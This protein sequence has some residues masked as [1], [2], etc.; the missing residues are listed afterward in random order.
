MTDSV[1]KALADARVEGYEL[2]PVQ[3]QENS[4]PAKRRSKKPMI[5]LP[6]SGPKLWDLW[7]TAW[8]RLD[9]DRSS[10]TEERREDGKVTYKVSGVQHVETSWDQQ[11]MELVKRMQPRIPE[12]GV[13]VQPV[14]GIFRV[15]ELPAWIYCTDDVK[16]LV[17]EHNFT[18]VSF[19]EMGDVLDEPLDDLPPIVP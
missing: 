16:R 8:T 12:E 17:E 2:R 4:E 3:M 13:F 5:K 18:N 6:Y 15:E 14:R 10:V 9:R 19:L 1:G 11:C 7:V